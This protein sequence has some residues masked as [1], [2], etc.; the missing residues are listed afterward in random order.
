MS[1]QHFKIPENGDNSCKR[2]PLFLW[3]KTIQMR[4]DHP[5][6]MIN[7]GRYKV[8]F[9]ELSPEIQDDVLKRMARLIDENREWYDR[10]NYG[11]L[12]NIL[13]TLAID[14]ALQATGKS[15]EESLA[16]LSKY[17]WASLKPEKMQK[18]AEKSYFVPLMKIVVPLGFKMGSGKGWRYVWHKDT[19]GPNEFHFE[20]TECLYKH[21]FT[22]YE[23]IDRFGSMFC[24][25]DIINY[26]NLPHTDFIRT[27]TLCQGGEVCDFYFVRHGKDEV[28]ERTKSV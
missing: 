28:W 12:C 11:H 9:S 8:C 27:Q 23:V 16:L 18:L 15:P 17:M 22:K 6:R 26:G 1:N 13:P 10:G 25:S 19:D 7:A 4:K 20:C 5:L 21:I 2:K 3:P 14:E 24:H